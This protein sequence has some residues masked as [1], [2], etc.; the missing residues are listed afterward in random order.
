MADFAELIK[1]PDFVNPGMMHLQPQ[2][3][4]AN[5]C[6]AMD[7][8]DELLYHGPLHSLCYIG[9]LE[10]DEGRLATQLHRGG[11]QVLGSCHGHP[12]PCGCTPREGHLGY[13]WVLAAHVTLA[14]VS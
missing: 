13:C 1:E 3:A 12:A 2:S 5:P 8:M 4:H 6:D 9:I 10:D 14:S 7:P 11:P